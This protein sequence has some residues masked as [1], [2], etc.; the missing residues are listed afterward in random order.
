M[1]FFLRTVNARGRTCSLY[2][3]AAAPSPF[4]STNFKNQ[5][6]WQAPHLCIHF[7]K[8][9]H[10][11]IFPESVLWNRGRIALYPRGLLTVSPR[12]LASFWLTQGL[13]NGPPLSPS[14]SFLIISILINIIIYIYLCLLSSRLCKIENCNRSEARK[15]CSLIQCN[16]YEETDSVDT[17][18]HMEKKWKTVSKVFIWT[19]KHFLLINTTDY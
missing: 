1:F 8:I 17:F 5:G 9:T 7:Y 16:A 2:P 15:L 11:V 12:S 10:R 19:E 6:S 13:I 4:L 14:S 18:L 3:S